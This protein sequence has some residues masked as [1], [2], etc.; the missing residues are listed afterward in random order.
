M[1]ELP[2]RLP[3]GGGRLPARLPVGGGWG[4]LVSVVIAEVLDAIQERGLPQPGGV[5]RETAGEGTQRASS[6]GGG[7]FGEMDQDLAQ[8]QRAV[9]EDRMSAMLWAECEPEY[10]CCSGLHTHR[11]CGCD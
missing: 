1:A 3:P 4:A 6:S 2:V 11:N 7:S 8:L 5:E 10:V 9:M